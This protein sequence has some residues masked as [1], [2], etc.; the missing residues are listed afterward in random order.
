MA[1]F[2]VVIRRLE[3]MRNCN[4]EDAFNGR[5]K[6][7]ATKGS[8]YCEEHKGW[9]CGLCGEQATHTRPIRELTGLLLCDNCTPYGCFK[10]FGLKT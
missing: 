10:P 6:Q 5:C 2:I 1:R 3:E 4:F 7:E 9:K 8:D